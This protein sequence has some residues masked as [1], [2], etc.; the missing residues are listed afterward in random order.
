MSTERGSA[1]ILMMVGL[2][3]V[4][5]VANLECVEAAATYTVGGAGGYVRCTTPP[6]AKVYR[7][8]K[9]KIRL[10]RTRSIH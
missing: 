5:M 4:V 3:L 2:V 10:L 7:S 1:I 8:G 9:D 6:M